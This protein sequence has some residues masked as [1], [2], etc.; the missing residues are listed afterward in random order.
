MPERTSGRGDGRAAWGN[1]GAERQFLRH[2][3]GFASNDRELPEDLAAAIEGECRFEI[4]RADEERM[5]STLFSGGDWRW[6][7]VTSDGLVLAE[8]AGYPNEGMCRAAV[9]VLQTRAATAPV[10]RR[11]E[12]A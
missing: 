3:G 7:L 1:G 2:D 8:A 9:S 12:P 4:F 5:T 6:R 10:T 11:G